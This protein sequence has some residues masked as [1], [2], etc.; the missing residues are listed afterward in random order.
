MRYSPPR[1][2]SL[3]APTPA[4]CETGSSASGTTAT[5]CDTGGEYAPGFCAP[6][7]LTA[8]DRCDPFGQEA[9]GTFGCLDGTLATDCGSGTTDGPDVGELCSAGGGGVT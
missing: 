1:L 5:S 6:S 9:G 8:G 4:R 7:G 3:S 2:R